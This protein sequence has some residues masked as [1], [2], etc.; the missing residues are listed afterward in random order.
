[1]VS[2]SLHID[3]IF[4]KSPQFASE[5]RF[6]N[7]GVGASFIFEYKDDHLEHCFALGEVAIVGSLLGPPPP[8]LQVID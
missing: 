1:M 3:Q 4:L 6:F 8:Q 7:E 2:C 5:Q